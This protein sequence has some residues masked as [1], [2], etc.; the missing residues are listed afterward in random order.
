VFAAVGCGRIA[1][2]PIGSDGAASPADA[3]V[4]A[5]WSA[6][7]VL[8]SASSVGNEVSP[9]LTDDG[10][11]LV[12]G[13]DRPGG[14]GLMDIYEAT[15]SSTDVPFDPPVELPVSTAGY[16][17]GPAISG[18]GLTLYFCSAVTQTQPP[19]ALK[20]ATRP[21]RT[22]PFT[23]QTIP[24]V[25]D[26]WGPYATRDGRE[27]FYTLLGTGLQ[28]ATMSGGVPTP[29]GPVTELNNGATGF[30]GLTADGLTIYYEAVRG[31]E[32]KSSIYIATRPAVGMPFGAETRVDELSTTDYD[33]DPDLSNGDR[34]IVFA[35]DR[36]PTQGGEDL[37]LATRSCR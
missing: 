28:R 11:D 16:D 13:S 2:D 29:V 36:S 35:S 20:R 33:S 25:P 30:A 32:T 31:T 17:D 3:C 37:Y 1:F 26:A 6:P 22:A 15:R 24:E 23:V 27:L 9:S 19:C 18:D 10:L 14:A 34:T 7:V 21:S 8:T 5:P 12:F 4:F